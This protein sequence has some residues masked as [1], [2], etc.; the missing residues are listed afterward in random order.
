MLQGAPL[1]S[2][3]LLGGCA[4]TPV[5]AHKNEEILSSRDIVPVHYT[6]LADDR[7]RDALPVFQVS[8]PQPAAAGG[9]GACLRGI[10]P[11]ADF[12]F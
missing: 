1:L 8:F 5:R 2:S 11:P 4:T 3:L 7:D 9:G 10:P 6:T 12:H